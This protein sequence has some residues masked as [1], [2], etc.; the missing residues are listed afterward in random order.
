VGE[1]AWVHT[2]P[3]LAI[4]RG[5][6]TTTAVIG[7]LLSLVVVWALLPAGGD[8]GVTALSTVVSRITDGPIE[9]LT[10]DTEPR[11]TTAPTSVADD[12]TTTAPPTDPTLAGSFATLRVASSDPT[13]PAS[14]A[15]AIGDGTLVLTTAAAVGDERV[16]ELHRA[17]GERTEARVLLVDQRSGLAVLAPSGDPLDAPMQV[18][19]DAHDGDEV[20]VLGDVVRSGLLRFTDGTAQLDSWDAAATTAEGTPVLDGSGDLVGL[21][22]GS[23]GSLRVLLLSDLDGLRAA[24]EVLLGGRAWMGVHLN[25][26]PSGL[27]TVAAVDPKGPA[28]TAVAIDG[29]AVTDTGQLAELIATHRPGDEIVV[30]VR[31]ADVLTDLTVALVARAPSL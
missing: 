15:V 30:T 28:A 6:L 1:A 23:S 17:S 7:G 2:E 10:R 31:R 14:V 3:P 20:T 19:P 25:D 21:C 27:L 22:S 4:G 26:D 13:V 18:A 5:L 8:P 16:V 11:P 12:A 29:A 9:A 24:I